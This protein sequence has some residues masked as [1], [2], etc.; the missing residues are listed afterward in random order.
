MKIQLFYRSFVTG[1]VTTIQFLTYLKSS[2][3]TNNFTRI[4]KNKLRVSL[5]NGYKEL[6]EV[7]NTIFPSLRI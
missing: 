4:F 3:K 7:N 2:L 5:D 1:H 6:G